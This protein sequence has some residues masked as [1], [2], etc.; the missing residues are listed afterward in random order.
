MK[1]R[2]GKAN[3]AEWQFNENKCWMWECRCN[4]VFRVRCSLSLY[5]LLAHTHI[6]THTHTHTHAHTHT[7]TRTKVLK[8]LYLPNHIHFTLHFH[9]FFQIE[10]LCSHQ[11]HNTV[12]NHTGYYL[13]HKPHHENNGLD[14]PVVLLL[15]ALP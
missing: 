6:H 7:R 5:L 3:T 9:A 12:H 14:I 10:A 8:R 15:A 4:R 11:K 2:N 1:C 13:T